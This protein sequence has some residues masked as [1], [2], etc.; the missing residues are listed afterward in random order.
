MEKTKVIEGVQ[1]S[2]QFHYHYYIPGD[3]HNPPEGGNIIVDDVTHKGES[4]YDLLDPL[5]LQRLVEEI[6]E[7]IS[8]I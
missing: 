6:R 2:V 4:I 3:Y 8:E 1:L 7:E 5:I